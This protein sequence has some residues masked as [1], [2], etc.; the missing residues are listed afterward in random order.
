MGTIT[1]GDETVGEPTKEGTISFGGE[2]VAGHDPSLL[3]KT[4]GGLAVGMYRDP[5]LKFAYDTVSE[6]TGAWNQEDIDFNG[7]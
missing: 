3:E 6:A 4:L 2:V 5:I 7:K 1:F